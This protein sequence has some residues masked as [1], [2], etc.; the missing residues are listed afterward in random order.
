[1]DYS[2]ENRH[3]DERLNFRIFDEEMSAINKII[4]HARD[5][6]G[7]KKYYSVSHFIRCSLV[8]LIKE[9]W[10]TLEIK[11]GRPPKK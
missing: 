6:Q 7:A 4:I 5:K 1:M 8:R 11:Q 2:I 3:F 9:E 10:R